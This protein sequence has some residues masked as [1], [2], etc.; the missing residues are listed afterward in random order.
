[1]RS[2]VV[3]SHLARAQNSLFLVSSHLIEVGEVLSSLETV[4]CRRFE[5]REE[6]GRLGFDFVLRPGISSQRLGFRVLQEEGVFDLLEGISGDEAA[7]G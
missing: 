1:M 6:G 2:R 7:G 4:D 5:A 3:F